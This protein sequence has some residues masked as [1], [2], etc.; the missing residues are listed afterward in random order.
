LLSQSAVKWIM[1]MWSAEVS[2]LENLTV[3]QQPQCRKKLR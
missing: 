3:N 1:D 2:C